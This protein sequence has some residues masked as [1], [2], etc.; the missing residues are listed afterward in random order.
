[1]YLFSLYVRAKYKYSK[2]SSSQYN[3]VSVFD[4]CYQTQL[5]QIYFEKKCDQTE[6][7]VMPLIDHLLFTVCLYLSILFRL[8]WFGSNKLLAF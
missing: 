2:T 7:N 5:K 3:G 8:K 4:V 6:M 1:M